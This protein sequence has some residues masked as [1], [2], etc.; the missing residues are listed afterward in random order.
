[1]LPCLTTGSPAPAIT[2]ADIVEI[3]TVCARSPPVPTMSTMR[4][5]TDNGSARAYIASTRPT[6]SVIVSPLARSA[7]ANPAIWAAVALPDRI[8]RIAHDVDSVDR[9]P[10][11]TRVVRTSG[12]DCVLELTGTAQIS[13]VAG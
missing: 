13:S 11:R 9:S 8:S 5:D 7:T 12:H 6:T 3:F 10:P 1:R 4:P 2:M